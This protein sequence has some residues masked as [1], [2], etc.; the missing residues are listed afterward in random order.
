MFFRA[1]T[2][3][4]AN[5]LGLTG[6]VRNLTDGRVEVMAF[7][8]EDKLSI[9]REW[10]HQGPAGANVTGVEVE[11]VAWEDHADFI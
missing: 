11:T 3:G 7:G 10:L 4:K 5:T 2:R 8:E 9:L 6:W 1:S